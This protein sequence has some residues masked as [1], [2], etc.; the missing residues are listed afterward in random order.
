[1]IRSQRVSLIVIFIFVPTVLLLNLFAIFQASQADGTTV[2][3]VVPEG[4]PTGPFAAC[5]NVFTSVQ[6]AVDDASGGDEIWVAGGVYSDVHVSGTMTQ[7]VLVDKALTLRGGFAAPF[8]ASPDVTANP[9]ILNADRRGRVIVVADTAVSIQG[10][11]ITGGNGNQD[12][13]QSNSG[14]GG[15]VFATNAVLTMTDNFVFD[16]IGALYE[17][18]GGGI[19]IKDSQF[20]VTKNDVYSNTA[21]TDISPTYTHWDDFGV[22]GGILIENSRGTLHDN[23]IRNNVASV[24]TV[25]QGGG[26]LIFDSSHITLTNN[27]VVENVGSYE[28]LAIGGGIVWSYYE[29]YKNPG[30]AKGLISHNVISGNIAAKVSNTNGEGG[31]LAVFIH[32]YDAHNESLVSIIAN[33]II[34]N[35]ALVSPTS[36]NGGFSGGLMVGGSGRYE[37]SRNRILSNTATGKSTDGILSSG[38]G[39]MIGS[40]HMTFDGDLIQFNQLGS[41]G[42]SSGIGFVEG[43]VI[44]MT[45]V[46]IA[47]NRAQSGGEGVAIYNGQV[48]MMHPT[49][50]RNGERGVFVHFDEHNTY[51][52]S[53][54]HVTVYN[55]ILAGQ[56]TG[57]VV[58]RTQT[59][60]VDGVLW[61]DTNFAYVGE[62]GA[63]ITINNQVI[64]D[65]RF[66]ADGYHI[67]EDSAAIGAGVPLIDVFTDIDGNGRLSPPSLG[68]DEYLPFKQVLPLILKE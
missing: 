16:N 39:V 12:T 34:S 50:V 68:A 56:N 42:N 36:S 66:A 2:F 41:R 24:H 49:I 26:I 1:M 18:G 30:P 9:T 51:P 7:V 14:F 5:S 46:V 48:T 3:C 38:G 20:T 13:S 23:T 67:T 44:T 60:T 61:H 32:N 25:G 10:F 59:L 43:G 62:P 4:A 11:Q 63:I 64:G 19:W 45:N 53:P 17:G 58:S 31:G 33:D 27:A 57:F 37:F 6:A 65:P 8:S 35:T 29:E 22:G 54:S 21:V 15:G 55:A 40:G 47:D 52:I 28:D